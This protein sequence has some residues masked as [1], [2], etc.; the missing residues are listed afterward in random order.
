MA[1]LSL[2]S[3]TRGCDFRLDEDDPDRDEKLRDSDLR[4]G[5]GNELLAPVLLPL[6]PLLL[7]ASLLLLDPLP[8]PLPLPPLP[9]FAADAAVAEAVELR[10]RNEDASLPSALVLGLCPN[11]SCD[12]SCR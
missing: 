12:C 2:D 6:S 8:L 11:C 1:A 5:S 4:S 9:R 10:E 3:S 7:P